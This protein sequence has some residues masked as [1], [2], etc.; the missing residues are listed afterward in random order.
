MN[1]LFICVLCALSSHHRKRLLTRTRNLHIP[2]PQRAKSTNAQYALHH[3]KKVVYECK[4]CFFSTMNRL[5]LRQH[6][7]SSH[8]V[9]RTFPCPQC[10]LKFTSTRMLFSHKATK[11]CKKPKMLKKCPSCD[12]TY[13]SPSRIKRHL[14]KPS[15]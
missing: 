2:R 1:I 3:S 4:Q 7:K 11:H 6:I 9:I 10:N 8:T 12:Y 14:G 5:V 15:F 13:Y